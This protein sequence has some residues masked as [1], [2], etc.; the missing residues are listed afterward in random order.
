MRW[1]L[2][3]NSKNNNPFNLLIASCF[4]PYMDVYIKARQQQLNVMTEKFRTQVLKVVHLAREPNA[5]VNVLGQ[6]ADAEY[7]NNATELFVFYKKCLVEFCKI[8]TGKPLLNLIEQCFQKYL[9]Q[10]SD[11]V[12]LEAIPGFRGTLFLGIEKNMKKIGQLHNEVFPERRAAAGSTQNDSTGN[13][14]SGQKLKSVIT[15]NKTSFTQKFTQL[16]S[17]VENKEVIKPIINLNEFKP[18][19]NAEICFTCKIIGTADWC[20]STAMQLEEKLMSKITLYQENVKNNTSNSNKDLA[21]QAAEQRESTNREKIEKFISFESE[22]TNIKKI[23]NLCIS[24]LVEDIYGNCCDKVIIKAIPRVKWDQVQTPGDTSLYVKDCQN[25]LT[26]K[27][28]FIRD[29]LLTQRIFFTNFLIKFVS[30]AFCPNLFIAISNCK[31]LP[32]V[33]AETLLMD[34]YSM[35]DFLINLPNVGNVGSGGRGSHGNRPVPVSYKKVVEEG[36]AKSE[37][38][39]QAIISPHS[40]IEKF[41][42]SYKQL[43]AG[44]WGWE[45]IFR[46]HLFTDV[47]KK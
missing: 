46:T 21:Q 27:V 22:L 45:I 8:S 6:L 10:Y 37:R 32:Q 39:L 3:A 2:S 33:A 24:S 18:M 41:V 17:F 34:V 35:K 5:E 43:M 12:L 7:F 42:N 4:E 40:D 31:V 23:I 13:N 29:N 25:R 19:N 38:L 30:Q 28:P 47:I 26:N 11:L 1:P 20:L 9:R 36:M 16:K 15:D 14:D 44:H